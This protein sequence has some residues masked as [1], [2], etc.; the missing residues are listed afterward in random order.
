[1]FEKRVVREEQ[2]EFWIQRKHLVASRGRGFNA[3]LNE[4][5][6]EMGFAQRVRV[7]CEPSYR[8]ANRGG[9]PGIE[10]V[11]YFK[12]LMVGFFENLGVDSSVIEKPMPACGVWNTATA[13]NL[14]GSMS[15]VCF[16]CFR[17][18]FSEDTF[19]Q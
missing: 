5:V 7:L 6:A 14:I 3:K 8:E 1:M 17:N 19:L 9:R 10:P 11:V 15:R 4:T 16:L 12:M 18:Q 2:G 13:S